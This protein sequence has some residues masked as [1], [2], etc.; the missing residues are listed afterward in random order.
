M[1]WIAYFMPRLAENAP[2]M[3]VAVGLLVVLG[4]LALITSIVGLFWIGYR[5]RLVGD[6][7]AHGL[8]LE[9]CRHL[10]KVCVRTQWLLA[11]LMLVG[12]TVWAWAAHADPVQ[13]E[14]AWVCVFDFL[15]PLLFAAINIQAA[16][17]MLVDRH[18]EHAES[19]LEARN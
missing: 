8:S 13:E 16:L 4:I 3:A 18:Q 9:R 12:V 15:M 19:Q 6:L 10:Q 11:L 17:R 1:R 2:A 5:W 7:R 14:V